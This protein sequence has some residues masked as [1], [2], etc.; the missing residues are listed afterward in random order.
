M[1]KRTIFAVI[2]CL[3]SLTA[4]WAGERSDQEMRTIALQHLAANQA[5]TRGAALES[6]ICELA[7][8]ASYSVYGLSQG[9]GFVVVSRSEAFNPVL[10]T[11]ETRFDADNL[12]DGLKWWLETINESL[13][14]REA[15][16]PTRAYTPVENFVMTQW[17][18]GSPYNSM[19]PEVGGKHCPTGCVATAMAQILKYYNY[20]EKSEGISYYNVGNDPTDI[21]YE[22]NTTFKWD[23]IQVSYKG[24]CSDESK[25]AVGEL[26]R[27][28]GYSVKMQYD[29]NGSAALYTNAAL[30]FVRNMCFKEGYV[31][32]A[33]RALYTDEEWMDIVE[34]EMTA[35]RPILYGGNDGKDSGHAFVFSGL[36]EDGKVYV[37]W[38]WDGAGDGYYDVANLA[39][40][41]NGVTGSNDFSQGQ[42]MVYGLTPD[43]DLTTLHPKYSEW[44]FWDGNYTLKPSSVA[45]RVSVD[46]QSS[47]YN[48]YYTTFR[49]TIDLVT[50][51]HE[52]GE[53]KT[54]TIY[55]TEGVQP[56]YGLDFSLIPVNKRLVNLKDLPAGVYTAYLGSKAHSD[57]EYQPLRSTEGTIAYEI[58][59]GEGGLISVSDPMKLTVTPVTDIRSPKV[60]TR[61][62]DA[63]YDLQGR[64]VTDPQRHGV[65]ILNG[66]KVIR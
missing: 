12:P 17:D 66:K 58:T 8:R 48:L 27:D 18:Q 25:Q 28:C 46:A 2:F 42:H 1:L 53:N 32:N 23:L 4:A 56:Y 52:T 7:R 41:G 19:T 51:S 26:M 11:S 43:P 61:T 10:A 24:E 36:A 60:V 38:G 14:T 34:R 20:P 50:I 57:V 45:G 39:P 35:H 5:N 22:F 47:L 3:L 63:L 31:H 16:A 15:A 9:Q 64:R 13:L 29:K 6:D 33:Y 40:T 21:R 54:F 62:A 30:G 37:N 55:Q 65:Y 59:I 49:G 44:A